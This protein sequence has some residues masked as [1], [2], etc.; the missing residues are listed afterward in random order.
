MKNYRLM[1][2]TVATVLVGLIAPVY[3]SSNYCIAVCGGFGSGGTT[4][5]GRDFAVPSAEPQNRRP[6]RAHC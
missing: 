4:F 1:A 3:A 2:T 6:A 5:I